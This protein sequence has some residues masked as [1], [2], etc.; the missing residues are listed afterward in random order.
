MN[1]EMNFNPSR[2]LEYA[3]YFSRPRH[4]GTREEKIIAQEISG[5]L[6]QLGYSVQNQDF[7]F[8][9]AF[10]RVLMVEIFLGL[11]LI[12][13]VLLTSGIN[14]WFTLLPTGL[15]MVLILL[16]NPVNRR[17]QRNSFGPAVRGGTSIWSSL[18]WKLGAHYE[19]RNIVAVLSA[20]RFDL[21]LPHLYLVAHYDSKSQYL[22]LA[23]RIALF[24]LV[25]AGSLVFSALVVF[26]LLLGTLIPIILAT[27]ILVII[28]G[29]P[30]LFLNY[31]NASAGAIDNASGLGLVLHL[32]VLLAGRLEL[33]G[34]LGVTILI[35]SAEELAVKGALAHVQENEMQLRNQASGGGLHV[36]NFDG[37][38]VDGKLYLV[39]RERKNEQGTN[40]GLSHLVRD[41]AV[42]SG[43]SLGR[44]S[45]PGA[46][47]DHVPFADAGFDAIT[48]VGIGRDSFSVHTAG[49]SPDK[50]NEGGIDQAGRLVLRV[51]EK[52]SREYISG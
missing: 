37:I 9:T 5:Q 46:L 39:G 7:Q 10:E 36:L 40:A 47:F 49:D 44:F 22:P 19:T 16:I 8:S 26:N 15:L 13:V 43:I 51:I 52:L 2:A 38:G 35:T 20:A 29:I 32:A 3:R 12:L 24:V 48:M 30:L 11:V 1:A 33:Y 14:R 21:N 42:E 25:I 45:L 28:S 23:M 34:K 18:C 6:E 4:V 41:C 27:G 50:L 31:G 17:V